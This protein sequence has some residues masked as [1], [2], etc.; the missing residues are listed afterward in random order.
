MSWPTLPWDT[1]ARVCWNT[2]SPVNVV[3]HVSDERWAKWF[4]M[5]THAGIPLSTGQN[6]AIGFE[7]WTDVVQ[8]WI[9]EKEHYYH[10]FPSTNF[11][12]RYTQ[13]GKRA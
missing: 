4:S 8:E 5:P 2:I 7:N 1:R 11:F 13:V 10:S 6:L 3:Y 12:S 9:E